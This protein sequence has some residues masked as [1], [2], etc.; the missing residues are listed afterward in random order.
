MIPQQEYLLF[1]FQIIH[2]LLAYGDNFRVLREIG[3]VD[4]PSF[5]GSMLPEGRGC[6]LVIIGCLWGPV[7]FLA[8]DRFVYASSMDDL[9]R[10]IQTWKLGSPIHFY[11]R[12]WSLQEEEDRPYLGIWVTGMLSE[13]VLQSVREC[14]LL[15]PC[16]PP[17]FPRPPPRVG[18]MDSL[19]RD[20]LQ[21]HELSQDAFWLGGYV[22]I[23]N[24]TG[25]PGMRV[26][27]FIEK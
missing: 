7:W 26:L 27:L 23:K 4:F 1:T 6:I 18:H 24:E 13:V 19:C 12:D 17:R 16:L 3:K 22:T 20:R 11:C 10:R 8:W 25:W 5:P 14:Q 9:L 15:F 2:Y 21:Y